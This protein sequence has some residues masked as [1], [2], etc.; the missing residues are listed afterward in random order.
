M[1]E[2]EDV[3]A[4]GALFATRLVRDL[5]SRRAAGTTDHPPQLKDL[6]RRVEL[7]VAAV[8]P[9][10]PEI[11][12]ADP[13]A[14]PSLLAR[15]ARRR[16]A[17]LY[18]RSAISSTD[19]HRIRLPEALDGLPAS[20]VLDRYR[21][22]ALEQAARASRRT[23]ASAPEAD[24]LLRDLYLLAEAAAIDCVL[25]RMLPRLR[26]TL[27]AARLE[28]DTQRTLI[29]QPSPREAAVDA[30]IHSLLS[31]DPA[32][33][34]APFIVAQTPLA[35]RRW[36]EAQYGHAILLSGPHRGMAPIALW[37]ANA[38]AQESPAT[39]DAVDGEGATRAARSHVLRRRPRVRDAGEDEDDA[40]PGTWMVRADDPQEKVEDPAGLQRPADRDQDAD[41]G[42]LADALSEL[43]E[44]RLVCS[45]GAICEILVC[46]DPIRRIPAPERARHAAGIV[47]PEWDWRVG[48]YRLHGA[49]VR[50]RP[51]EEGDEAW[52]DATL[53]RHAAM[54][55]GV[56][57]DFERLRPRRMALGRQ[58]D[59][60]DIDVD[61]VVDAFAD[62]RGGGVS[63]DR[64]YIDVRPLRRDVAI[65]LL[66]DTSASTDGWVSGDRRIID[67]EKEALLV[68]SEA[69][70]A[71][72][73]PHTILSFSGE[74]PARVEVRTVREFDDRTRLAAFRRRIAGLE[75]GGY[76]RAGTA[77]RHA[78]ARLMRQAARHRL[79]LLLS[80]GRPND[81]DQYEGRYGVEDTRVA[82][83]E[84]RLQGLHCFCLTVD[85][86]APRYA[87]RI[88]GR[89]F[90][91]LSR[92]ERLPTVLT[93][94]L[95]DLVRG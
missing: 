25:V 73:D 49:T 38:A 15:L 72:G 61:A 82:V 88:F 91:V 44:A 66:V 63:D 86:E 51:A 29:P 5:W 80:D 95:R 17:H 23:S 52:V 31:A 70:A 60:A 90:A 64:L 18:S 46:E 7:F 16:T 67:V 4:E 75:P 74:G 21:L 92:A 54:L 48:A 26:P 2:P 19:G 8:F 76:T 3:I 1:A 22:L 56:R 33:P 79:L 14:P 11:G 59:G 87:T 24:P 89:D 27:V 35:S 10:A 45:P 39:A 55:R 40:E 93:A 20:A 71:L 28:S 34:P 85:R 47:Y 81:V 9:D 50:E 84:A 57:R 77:I 53:R 69:L 94:L 68:V 12:V 78:T 36:A 30:L 32:T 41:A 83:A 6:R 37:G 13:P 42:E 43:P 62:R 58:P 65:A